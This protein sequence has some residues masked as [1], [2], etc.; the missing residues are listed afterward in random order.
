MQITPIGL[1]L[2]KHGFQV[3]GV[4]AAGKVVALA[5]NDR[6]RSITGV[7][8]NL[9]VAVGFRVADAGLVAR[10]GSFR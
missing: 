8:W 3:H 10:G 4:D 1:D 5:A 7:G 2:A 6:N 9:G